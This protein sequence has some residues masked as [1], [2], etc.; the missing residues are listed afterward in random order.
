MIGQL[1]PYWWSSLPGQL[2]QWLQTSP[3]IDQSLVQS[4]E[5]R[6]SSSNWLKYGD[7]A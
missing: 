5:I 3:Y 7:Q 6:E 4:V 2:S 1:V